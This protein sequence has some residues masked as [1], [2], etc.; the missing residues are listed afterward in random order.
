MT[1]NASAAQAAA[2]KIGARVVISPTTVL[3]LSTLNLTETVSEKPEAS[4]ALA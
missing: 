1:R 4:M 3:G 2:K